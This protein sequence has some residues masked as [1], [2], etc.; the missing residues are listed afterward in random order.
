MAL[1]IAPVK[2]PAPDDVW[3]RHRIRIETVTFDASYPTGGE[4]FTP[5][6]VGM[7]EFALVVPSVDANS[8]KGEVVQYDYTAQK[9]VVLGVEQDAD[10]TDTEALDEEDS[11]TDLSTL[12]VRV[13]IVGI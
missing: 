13:L 8:L 7:S 2:A 10:G 12:V 5:A 3:G 1:S 6:M 9:L 11:T 4:S